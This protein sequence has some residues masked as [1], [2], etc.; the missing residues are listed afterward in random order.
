[1]SNAFNRLQNKDSDMSSES[2]SGKLFYMARPL[3][4]KLQLP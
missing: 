1:M 2:A 3:T 4:A